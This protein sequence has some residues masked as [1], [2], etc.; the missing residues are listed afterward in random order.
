MPEELDYVDVHGC[1][2]IMAACGHRCGGGVTPGDKIALCPNCQLLVQL[3]TSVPVVYDERIPD[4]IR[5]RH[6]PRKREE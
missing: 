3:G 1:Q 4:E 2:W 5:E 6:T